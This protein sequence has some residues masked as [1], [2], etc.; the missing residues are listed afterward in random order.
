[1]IDNIKL[2]RSLLLPVICSSILLVVPT[3]LNVNTSHAF[4]KKIEEKLKRS[5]TRS[6]KP[7]ANATR[8]LE[9][10]IKN[11]DLVKVIGTVAIAVGAYEL[12][13]GEGIEGVVIAGFGAALVGASEKYSAEMARKYKSDLKWS[14]CRDCKKSRVIATP[15]TTLS[16]AEKKSLRSVLVSDVKSVQEALKIL[17]FY[18]MGVDGDYGP[19]TRAAVSAF[20]ISIGRSKGATLTAFERVKLLDMARAKDDDFAKRHKVSGTTTRS[21]AAEPSLIAATDL[22]TERIDV[23]TADD[24]QSSSG[25]SISDAFKIEESAES[26]DVVER[27]ITVATVSSEPVACDGETYLNIVFPEGDEAKLSHY[28]ISSTEVTS[29]VDNGDGT[30]L[31]ENACISGEF[32]YSYVI[33]DKIG[34]GSYQD[35]RKEGSFFL[36]GSTSQCDVVLENPDGEGQVECY[37]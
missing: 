21:L 14:G 29:Y 33:F 31:L 26:D 35:I 25:G 8:E 15:G 13:N 11:K 10:A 37:G 17:G 30:L 1:M 32:K 3:E 9:K 5:L 27:E 19:G 4:T 36:N 23:E 6:V 2:L 34:D 7:L 18:T 22:T 12:L 16:A 24:S 20:K 28:N